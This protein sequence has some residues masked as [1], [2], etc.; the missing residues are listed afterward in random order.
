MT[1]KTK[2]RVLYTEHLHILIT[3]KMAKDIEWFSNQ[4]GMAMSNFVRAA[5]TDAINEEKGKL[6]KNGIDLD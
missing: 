3:Q 5:L 1:K 6:Q 2:E 4:R